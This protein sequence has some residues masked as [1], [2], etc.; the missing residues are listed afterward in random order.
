MVDE[1]ELVEEGAMGAARA[2]W[3]LLRT[4]MDARERAEGAGGDEAG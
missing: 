4:L 2:G 3:L 1:L